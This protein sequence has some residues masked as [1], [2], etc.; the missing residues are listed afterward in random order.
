[1]RPL[2]VL[3]L[4]GRKGKHMKNKNSK[5]AVITAAL[6]T[7]AVAGLTLKNTPA[8]AD[9]H[10]TEAHKAD[11]K[12]SCKNGCEGKDAKK[13]HKKG[14][15]AHEADHGKQHDEHHGEEHDEAGEE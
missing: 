9:K 8:F 7:L 2:K 15:K 11:D 14:D 1:M 13:K 10:K 3:T 5:M 4:L 12:H 6:A